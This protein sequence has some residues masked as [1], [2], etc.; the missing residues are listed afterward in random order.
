MLHIFELEQIWPMRYTAWLPGN[1][2]SVEH[3]WMCRWDRCHNHTVLHVRFH[4][5]TA[6]KGA[7]LS[8]LYMRARSS[9]KCTHTT[10][11]SQ[12]YRSYA[13]RE[14]GRREWN[15]VSPCRLLLCQCANSA[16]QLSPNLRGC[17]RNDHAI[18]WRARHACL[19]PRLLCAISGSV[20]RNPLGYCA[21]LDGSAIG[22]SLPL[23]GCLER[24]KAGSTRERERCFSSFE[25]TLCI[26]FPARGWV[27]CLPL[28]EA[29][30]R[31]RLRIHRRR[32]RGKGRR[33]GVLNAVDLGW[34]WTVQQIRD[35]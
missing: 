16:R 4:L 3:R 11:F 28:C 27:C 20:F 25:P 1:C 32:Q 30:R 12:F 8:L 22:A 18:E 23:N 13:D 34:W 5:F 26:S 14:R 31:G 9:L 15:T 35:H 2:V 19:P 33:A 24:G 17:A 10:Y 6:H 21:A 29:P 7:A